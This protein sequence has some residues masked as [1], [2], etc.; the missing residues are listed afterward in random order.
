M[1]VSS[2]GDVISLRN[3]DDPGDMV[4]TGDVTGFRM[5]LAQ[6]TQLALGIGWALAIRLGFGMWLA[7]ATG[8][9]LRGQL[10]WGT[11]LAL[12]TQPWHTP[13]LQPG[14]P[15]GTEG[16]GS[17]LVPGTGPWNPHSLRFGGKHPTPSGWGRA[18]QDDTSSQGAPRP[19]RPSDPT[20]STTILPT[21]DL[22][23]GE[24]LHGDG[25]PVGAMGASGRVPCPHRPT[26][27]LHSAQGW[28]RRAGGCSPPPEGPG[29][30]GDGSG[31]DEAP[32]CHHLL[33]SPSSSLR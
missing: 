27:Q 18:G 2:P 9:T 19:S 22:Q 12:G 24:G 16:P 6:G 33:S 3:T 1:A 8:L 7:L 11:W 28:G 20:H 30:R 32:L 4:C 5:W 13:P 23:V 15:R 10:A 29:G 26:Q 31:Q 17:R 14:V 21:S 25:D